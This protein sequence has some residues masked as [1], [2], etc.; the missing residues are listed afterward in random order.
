MPHDPLPRS[1]GSRRP[2]NA[3]AHL[4]RPALA[5]SAA[6]GLALGACAGPMLPTMPPGDGTLTV[7]GQYEVIAGCI[8]EASEKS[9]VGAASLRVDRAAQKATVQRLQQPANQVLYQ[10]SFQQ[11]GSTRVL[12]EGRALAPTP[13]AAN[14]F[15]FLWSQ[16]EG[17][18]RDRMAP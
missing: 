18:A 12:V 5:L 1:P 2:Q 17:C 4:S 6:L 10:I 9:T 7:Q 13:E 11:L 15:A 14:A 8:V 3:P 16:V